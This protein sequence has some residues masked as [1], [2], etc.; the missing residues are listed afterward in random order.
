MSGHLSSLKGLI[1]VDKVDSRHPCGCGLKVYAYL[2]YMFVKTIRRIGISEEF[3]VAMKSENTAITSITFEISYVKPMCLLCILVAPKT[4]NRSLASEFLNARRQGRVRLDSW[5]PGLQRQFE[6]FCSQQLSPAYPIA[7]KKP[8]SKW[9]TCEYWFL[10]VFGIRRLNSVLSSRRA[11]FFCIV[12]LW[13]HV[14]TTSWIKP[15]PEGGAVGEQY[16]NGANWEVGCQST[17]RSRPQN[18]L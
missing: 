11:S 13:I 2:A 9:S 17:W 3:G 4:S 16:R 5:R 15:R 10:D 8:C 14:F 7:R 18:I 1:N 6:S 12:A